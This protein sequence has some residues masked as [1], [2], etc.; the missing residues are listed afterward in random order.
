VDQEG[1]AWTQE[2]ESR[3]RADKIFGQH[4]PIEIGKGSR[5]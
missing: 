4:G 1:I 5:F 3:T 2:N